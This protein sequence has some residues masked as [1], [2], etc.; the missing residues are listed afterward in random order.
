MSR[1]QLLK[2]YPH[3]EFRRCWT[4][5]ERTI[6]N[7]G[8]CDSLITC[9]GDLPVDPGV[10]ADLR[11]VSFERGAQATTAIEGNTL[12]DAELRKVVAGKPLPESRTYQ[13]KEVQ[14]A[15][16]LMNALH[17]DVV[18][19]NQRA[20]ITPRFLCSLNRNIGKGLGPLY[21]GA[22]G[23]VRQDRRHVGRYL[24][25]PP[26]AASDFN[27]DRESRGVSRL[28][29]MDSS[30]RRWQWPHRTDARVLCPAGSGSA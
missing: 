27:G 30:L 21:D 20:P 28:L 1:S 23:K 24:A 15:L 18:V 5:S 6:L 12:T 4:L 26:E 29:R 22:P 2:D 14:N 25:P 3:L 9:L 13:A 10:Q 16:D 19:N 8:K 11:R 17:L 7:L